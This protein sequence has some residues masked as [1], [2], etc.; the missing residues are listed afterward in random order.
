MISKLREAGQIPLHALGIVTL[1]GMTLGSMAY[2]LLSLFDIS[3]AIRLG[4]YLIIS[5]LYR[6]WYAM[7]FRHLLLLLVVLWTSMV[8]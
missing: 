5:L 2:H 7:T 1:R 8:R 4:C 6:S 3:R